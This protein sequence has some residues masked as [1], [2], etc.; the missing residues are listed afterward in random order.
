MP[1]TIL[2]ET[3]GEQFTGIL[4]II[5][6]VDSDENIPG[7]QLRKEGHRH[8]DQVFDLLSHGES[9][10]FFRQN[11]MELSGR[12]SQFR[13][14]L[15]CIMDFRKSLVDVESELLSSLLERTKETTGIFYSTWMKLEGKIFESG[16]EIKLATAP[17]F[18]AEEI[19]RS[20]NKLAFSPGASTHYI[21]LAEC[22][23]NIIISL[24]AIDL[25][26]K[27]LIVIRTL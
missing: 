20:L 26:L 7:T 16:R 17:L 12:I 11:Y 9:L 8:S 3:I 1:S 6:D 10:P 21:C 27:K 5:R 15:I 2:L 13:G 22:A 25:A 18:K 14:E 24:Q 4:E 23:N 19:A